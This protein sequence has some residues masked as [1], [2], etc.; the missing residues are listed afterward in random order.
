MV[1]SETEEVSAMRQFSESARRR[2]LQG[3]S[4]TAGYGRTMSA[5][6]AMLRSVARK[7]YCTARPPTDSHTWK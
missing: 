2:A 7:A 3:I 6:A 4:T 5:H 1:A